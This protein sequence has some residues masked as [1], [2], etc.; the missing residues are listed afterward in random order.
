MKNCNIYI[1]KNLIND[2]VY[3]GQ[4][5]CVEQRWKDHKC[6]A[7]TRNKNSKFYNAIRK[8]G[9]ENFY[10]ETLETN[11]PS[12]DIER[13][14]T[15]YIKKFNS[16]EKGYNSK[17]REKRLS[18]VKDYDIEEL[19]K[20][21]EDGW[22]LKKIGKKYGSDKKEISSLLREHGVQIRDWNKLQ[23]NPIVTKEFLEEEINTKRKSVK[24][25]AKEVNLSDTAIRNWMK[26]FNIT[27][28]NATL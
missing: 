1:V 28:Q 15:E 21:Y 7:L 19:K 9:I 17:Y 26:K 4:T 2:K 16:V 8:Y 22:S 14:E 5:T 12:E 27:I 10:I 11:I 23:S 24:Q 3:I 18:R 6:N 13:I 20:L 25:I